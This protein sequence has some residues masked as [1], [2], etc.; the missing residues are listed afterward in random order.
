MKIT[1]MRQIRLQRKWTLE[2]VAIQIGTTKQTVHRIETKQRSPS[3]KLVIG[4]QKIFKKPIDY[5]LSDI[6]NP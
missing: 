1:N 2:Y 4:L 5:L 3:C 6:D